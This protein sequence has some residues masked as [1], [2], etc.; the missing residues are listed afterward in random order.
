MALVSARDLGRSLEATSTLLSSQAPQRLLW[1]LSP[2][3]PPPPTAWSGDSRGQPLTPAPHR[4][5][6]HPAPLTFLCPGRATGLEHEPHEA[7]PHDKPQG[8]R[9]TPR[10]RPGSL[11]LCPG[12]TCAPVLACALLSCRFLLERGYQVPDPSASCSHAPRSDGG[13]PAGSPPASVPL[14]PTPRRV[15]VQPQPG[16]KH[17]L[18]GA[19]GG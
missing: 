19:D 2:P 4:P 1:A 14:S 13:L 17:W 3:A 8:L 9:V 6:A 16:S 7:L 10:S 15:H 11:A 5:P 12:A 18:G